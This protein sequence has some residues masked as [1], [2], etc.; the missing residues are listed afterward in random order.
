M[1]DG[2]YK[3][4]VYGQVEKITPCPS[5]VICAQ[6][7][8]PEKVNFCEDPYPELSRDV[9]EDHLG[10]SAREVEQTDTAADEQEH[11][12][13]VEVEDVNAMESDRKMKIK[14]NEH[15][16]IV[17]LNSTGDENGNPRSIS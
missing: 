10:R 9:E 8:D 14:G 5:H 11:R 15:D 13:G 6:L 1:R 17:G 2:C 7:Q 12:V 16:N 4:E 3:V